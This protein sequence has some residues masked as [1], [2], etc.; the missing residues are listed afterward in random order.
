MLSFLLE[1]FEF[2]LAGDQAID[3][4]L[5]IMLMPRSDPLVLAQPPKTSDGRPGKLAGPVAGLLDVTA[6]KLDSTYP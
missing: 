2:T 1:Q 4:R 3:W 6:A 5:H